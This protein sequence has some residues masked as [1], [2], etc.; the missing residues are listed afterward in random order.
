MTSA[1]LVPDGAT[2]A[3]SRLIMTLLAAQV[4]GS[5]G[6]TLTLAVGSI[7]AADLTGDN[8]LSGVPVAVGAL[9]G[10]LASVPLSRLMGR[11]GRRPGLA[12]GYLLAV[13]GSV[14]SMVGVIDRSFPL[15][16]VGHVPVRVRAGVQPA[17]A[18]R[19]RRRQHGR[20]AWPGDRL[21]RR[22]RD[23]R[24]DH[25]PEPD[26]A[27]H[28]AS[29][30][31]RA[32]G[33]RRAVPDRHRRVRAG[34]A[35]DRGAVAAGPAEDRAPLPPSAMPW[36]EFG[37]AVRP[38]GDHPAHAAHPD[39]LRGADDEPARD[40]RHDLD[41]GGLPPGPRPRRR[42]DRPGR[43][44]PPGRDVRRLADH[45]LAGGPRRAAGD[46]PDRRLPAD[47]GGGGGGAG[48]RAATACW[49]R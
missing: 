21:D 3:R 28:H 45:G 43:L 32:A 26:G 10:A 33:R 19:R 25:R 12:L 7:V 5:T 6:H 22:G 37:R 47:R 48:A 27:G 16:L 40:D 17:R 34:G 14:L 39:R 20:S 46:D 13:L 18:V 24:L 49:W 1:M 42:D 31:A 38:L 2:A 36:H 35:A 11:F 15:F 41:G 44:A 30:R 29:R 23:G 8:T 9:G 4:C